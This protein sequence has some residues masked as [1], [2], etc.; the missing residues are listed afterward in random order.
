[1]LEIVNFMN[2]QKRKMDEMV[3]LSFED[4]IDDVLAYWRN[5]VKK[6]LY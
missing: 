5:F 3:K 4:I 6:D 1:M 2:E